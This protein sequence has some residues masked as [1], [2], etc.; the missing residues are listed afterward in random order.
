M[1]KQGTG[2]KDEVK[3]QNKQQPETK[4]YIDVTLT[5]ER[6]EPSSSKL[7]VILPSL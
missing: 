1:L 4:L 2:A 3:K 6:I 5:L 7:N